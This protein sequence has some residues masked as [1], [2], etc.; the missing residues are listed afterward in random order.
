LVPEPAAAASA[1]LGSSLE[2]ASVISAERLNDASPAAERES[3]DE[4]SVAIELPEDETA[5]EDASRDPDYDANEDHADMGGEIA[6]DRRAPSAEE[7]KVSAATASEKIWP[8]TRAHAERLVAWLEGGPIA[9]DSAAAEELIE[10]LDQDFAAIARL[11]AGSDRTF[12]DLRLPAAKHAYE[13]MMARPLRRRE[14]VRFREPVHDL[15]LLQML[16]ATLRELSDDE[17]CPLLIPPAGIG[18]RGPGPKAHP[19]WWTCE[20]LGQEL[21]SP[22]PDLRAANGRVLARFFPDIQPRILQ[23]DRIVTL[24][25]APKPARKRR[26]EGA[27]DAACSD[28]EADVAVAPDGAMWLRGDATTAWTFR[29]AMAR[30]T[31]LLDVAELGRV[32]GEIE[33][34]A[35]QLNLRRKILAAV[36]ALMA[37]A[38]GYDARR[39]KRSLARN[40]AELPTPFALS[41]ERTLFEAWRHARLQANVPFEPSIGMP[42]VD[43]LAPEWIARIARPFCAMVGMTDHTGSPPEAAPD[44]VTLPQTYDPGAVDLKFLPNLRRVSAGTS[45]PKTAPES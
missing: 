21:K 16:Y 41:D 4:T 25:S 38:P 34:A 23:V 2:A 17:Q 5:I 3:E 18:A 19:V 13:K 35:W 9:S 15:G 26:H 7:E 14:P 36:A 6:S 39:V 31:R 27:L 42:T 37:D 22:D 20:A 12:D 8:A 29:T 43:V 33:L 1:D 44:P 45:N 24:L 11:I 10:L 40:A 30:G 32:R 28:A